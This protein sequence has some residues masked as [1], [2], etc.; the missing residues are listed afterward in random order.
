M[1]YENFIGINVDF[2]SYKLIKYSN[3]NFKWSDDQ[4]AF[5][6]DGEVGL[7]NIL[8]TDINAQFESYF[9]IRKTETGEIINLFLRA[10]PE[11]WYF[12]SYEENKLYIYTSNEE[13]NEFVKEKTNIGKAKI[14]EFQ[15]GPSDFDEMINFIQTFRAVYFDID[16][17]YDLQGEVSIKKK[18]DSDKADEE[19]DGF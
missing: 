7:S 8:R 13:L 14:G 11:S 6:N 9:E 15:F 2:I 19:D 5:Y 16:E 17:P 12:F 10:S 18:K 3:V 4:K 1:N